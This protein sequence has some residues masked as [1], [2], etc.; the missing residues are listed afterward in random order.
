M[1]T[2]GINKVFL[3]GNLGAAPEALRY[4][5]GGSAVINLRLA[6][7]E[8]WKDR[9]SGEQQERTEWHRV[10]LYGRLAEVAHQYLRKGSKIWVEGRLQTREWEKEGQKHYTT[11]VIANDM[12]MLD[13][14]NNTGSWEASTSSS[15]TAGASTPSS[16]YAED[17]FDD[18][19]PF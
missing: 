8:S 7:S 13:T 19:I 6:T 15:A 11:E 17:A 10:V 1:S 3:I 9:Q 4:T 2:R 16:S 5:P 18:D 12:Q 14:R